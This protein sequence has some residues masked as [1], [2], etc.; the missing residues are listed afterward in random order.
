MT[1]DDFKKGGNLRKFITA[2]G[3]LSKIDK[4]E[5]NENELLKK[6]RSFVT[7]SGKNKNTGNTILDKFVSKVIK[8]NQ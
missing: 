1:L 8:K 3:L 4:S 7:V 2:N 6:L 5:T